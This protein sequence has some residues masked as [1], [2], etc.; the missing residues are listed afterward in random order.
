MTEWL[1][2]PVVQ[3]IIALGLG[4]LV[5][6]QREWVEAKPLGLRSF[7][8]ITLIGALI[9]LYASDAGL[10]IVAVGLL[11]VTLAI[12]VHTILLA[13]ETAVTG[14]TTELAGI[15]MYMVGAMMTT[16][17]PVAA[18]VLTG[19]VTLLLHW[20]APLHALTRRIAPEE[21]Q[22]IARFVLV[23]LAL[24]MHSSLAHEIL[25][26][27]PF[28]S[29]RAGTALGLVQLGVAIPYLRFKRLHLAHHRDSRL[30]D[31]YDDPETNYMDPEVW[32][33]L[34]RWQRA[35]LRFNNTLLGRMVVGPAV[36]QWVFMR[37]DWRAIRAGDRQVLGDWLMHIPSV[38]IVGGALSLSAMSV[39]AYLLACYCALS[40]LKIR[41]FLEHRAHDDSAARTVVIE[42][43]C[44]LS[45]LFLNNSLHAV[46]HMHPTV[47]WYRLPA[48]Y[49][50]DR[51]GYLARN[52]GYAYR[53][54]G[55]VFREHFWRAKDPVPHPLWQDRAK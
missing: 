9:G 55:Q 23:T 16:G 17:Y 25:H 19:V 18:V 6:L 51:A 45:F 32:Q 44:P 27:H 13:R 41:T 30:T 7:A 33:G 42:G 31:P 8:L 15:A 5:G 46:H 36:S 29:R 20:K 2:L 28:P 52:Q 37:G 47:S 1:N 50:A 24:V 54:Y 53:S 12:F 14:M 39:W 26:G 21:F 11:V 48:L 22:A 34:P 49:R 43:W 3:L 35:V 4:L 10:W 40:V 38:V